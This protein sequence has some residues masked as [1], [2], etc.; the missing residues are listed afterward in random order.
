MMRPSS[1]FSHTLDEIAEFLKIQNDSGGIRVTGVTSNSKGV[2]PGDLFVAL[3]GSRVHGLDFASQAIALGAV[4]IL[5]DRKLSQQSIPSL[6]VNDPRA[7]LGRLANWFYGEPTRNLAVYGITGTN[8]KTTTTHLLFQI[9]LRNGI[10][11]GLIG[12]VGLQIGKEQFPAIHT[13]PEADELQ[14]TFAAM[15][16]KGARV[17]AMEVSSHALVQKRVLGTRFRASGFTNLTQDH[18]DFHATMENYFQAKRSLFQR[19]HSERAFVTVDDEYGRRLATEVASEFDDDLVTLSTL[20][21]SA[22]WRYQSIVRLPTGFDLVIGGPN[23]ISISGKFNLVGEHNL[24]NLLLAVALASDSG[25]GA[26]EIESA[27]PYLTGAPGRLE[28]VDAGQ[29]FSVLVDYAHTPDALEQVLKS[30]RAQ[31]KGQLVCVFG[32]GGDRDSGKRPLMGKVASELADKVIVTSDNPRGELPAGIIQ[33]V[34]NGVKQNAISIENRSEAID[35]AIKN[36]QA[37]DVILLAG[38]GHENYQEIA[39]V[40]YPF[41]D[42]EKAQQFLRE[43]AA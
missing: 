38:K 10:A 12:T 13:T 4:A 21:A 34:M 22:D 25:V 27:L 36:A 29:P 7:Q 26:R 33:A 20:E 24:Q 16:E 31:T 41:S 23:N 3:P 1:T 17:I 19:S 18:L 6:V 32:C 15:F 8:G 37:G 43:R 9:W 5:S 28:R 39:G 42:I 30:L 14:S 2:R 40:K 35:H 11:S